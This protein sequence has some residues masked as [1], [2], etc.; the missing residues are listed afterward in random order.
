MQV[1]EKTDRRLSITV[2]LTEDLSTLSFC[3]S[4]GINVST[5]VEMLPGIQ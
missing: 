3:V 4:L 2:Q 1:T 5:A